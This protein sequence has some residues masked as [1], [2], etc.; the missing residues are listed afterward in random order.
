MA[1]PNAVET[2]AERKAREN[3]GGRIGLLV[4]VHLPEIKEGV[5]PM[6][7][8]MSSFEQRIEPQSRE[9]QYLVV[10]AEPYETIAFKLQSKEVDKSEKLVLSAMP[11]VK[12]R[13]EPGTWTHWDPDTKVYSE[14]EH[15]SICLDPR[16]LNHSIL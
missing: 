12:P 5:K 11:S 14:S 1:I 16:M 6:H 15:G 9:W 2:D 3:T 4:K 8:F 13:D 10:A 7:R